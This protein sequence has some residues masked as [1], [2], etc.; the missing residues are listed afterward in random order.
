VHASSGIVPVKAIDIPPEQYQ[1]ALR[2]IEVSFLSAPILTDRNQV[3]IPLPLTPGGSWSWL[4]KYPGGWQETAVVA[5]VRKQTFA[6]TFGVDD[7]N[8]I[9]LALQSCGWINVTDPILNIANVTAR[10]QRSESLPDE[11][12]NRQDAIEAI[13]LHAA[14]G[15]PSTQAEFTGQSRL[16]EGWLKL[17]RLNSTTGK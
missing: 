10:D 2:N 8:G 6:D 11:Y 9:W 3:Q 17:Q 13:L 5:L 4:E 7:T 16:A 12:S 1:D 14:I 15:T